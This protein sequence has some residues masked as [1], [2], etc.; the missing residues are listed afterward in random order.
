MMKLPVLVTAAGALAL[1][2][3]ARAAPL[4]KLEGG[5]PTPSVVTAWSGQGKKVELTLV[6]GTDPRAVA[7]AIEA[8][9]DRVRA[10]VKGGR[11]LVLGKTVADLL[12][13]LAEIDLEAPEDDL[14]TLAEASLATDAIDSGSSL[15]AKKTVELKKLLSDRKRTAVGTVVSVTPRV[16][17][18]AEVRIRILRA[19]TGPLKETVRKGKTLM[20]VP[21]LRR[22]AGAVDFTDPQT[23][24]NLGAYFLKKRDRVNIRIGE[25][26]DGRI[27]AEVIMR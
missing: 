1:V 2:A 25:P 16:F 6:E 27:V 26:Q 10:K 9:V 4:V 15:R 18:Y 12:P 7:A 20:F 8:N 24:M 21:K 13:A 5:T 3:L 17:P 19:P 14:A 11:V 22:K 23:Q